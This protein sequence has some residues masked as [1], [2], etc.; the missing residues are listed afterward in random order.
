MP[1][2][3]Q[4]SIHSI[5]FADDEAAPERHI[6]VEGNKVLV[7]WAEQVVANS[8]DLLNTAR[9]DSSPATLRSVDLI[10]SSHHLHA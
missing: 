10:V 7:S 3:A 4:Q 2:C 6:L 9:R 5:I 1:V 8:D